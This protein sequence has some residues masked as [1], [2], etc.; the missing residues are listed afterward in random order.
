MK[1]N[2]S[3]CASAKL[4]DSIQTEL[5][6]APNQQKGISQSELMPEIKAKPSNTLDSA[7]QNFSCSQSSLRSG[8]GLSNLLVLLGNLP[9]CAHGLVATGGKVIKSLTSD[10]LA[11][12][13]PSFDLAAWPDDFAAQVSPPFYWSCLAISLAVL[14]G[15][16]LQEER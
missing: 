1:W 7:L 4:T 10:D 5:N 13:S 14:M 9:G 8:S 6:A 16:L 2:Q 15:W 11:L 3:G 12:P